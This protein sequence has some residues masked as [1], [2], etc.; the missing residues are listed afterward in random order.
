M[1][2]EIL[3]VSIEKSG[4]DG[5]LPGKYSCHGANINPPLSIS[6]IPENTKS[7]A[8]IMETC[9]LNSNVL[10][11]WVL[12]NVPAT[13]KILENEQRGESGVNDFGGVG[14]CGPCSLDIPLK[15]TFKIY[16]FDRFLNFDYPAVTKFDLYASV[17]YYGLGYGELVLHYSKKSAENQLNTLE[18]EPEVLMRLA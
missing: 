13:G 9:D 8:L 4:E 6:N 12:W 17:I 3:K 15:C 2:R 5:L 14:Y 11:H 10:T 16:A 1:K 18:F 7:L